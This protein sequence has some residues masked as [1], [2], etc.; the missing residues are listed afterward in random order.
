MLIRSRTR[1]G[2]LM[3]LAVFACLLAGCGGVPEFGMAV[4]IAP[5]RWQPVEPGS[6]NYPQTR[7]FNVHDAQRSSTGDADAQ[8]YARPDGKALCSATAKDGGTA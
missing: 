5:E 8:S 2:W 1:T 4:Q 7:S 6:Q 3:V